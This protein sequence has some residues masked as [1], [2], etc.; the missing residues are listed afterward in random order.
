ML[1]P[2][3]EMEKKNT[4]SFGKNDRHEKVI[5]IEPA[6]QLTHKINLPSFTKRRVAGYARVST[7]HEDQTTS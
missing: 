5:M 7:D 3:I 6:K 1:K 2:P 4:P